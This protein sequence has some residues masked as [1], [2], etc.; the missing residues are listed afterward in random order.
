MLMLCLQ[1]HDHATAQR[2]FANH[3]PFSKEFELKVISSGNNFPDFKINR[4]ERQSLLVALH[5]GI[6]LAHFKSAT[7]LDD[8]EL[9][10]VISFLLSKNW[11]N[12]ESDRYKPNVFIA[13]QKDGNRLYE[14][15]R[16]LSDQIAQSI[17]VQLPKIK[18]DFEKTEISKK[19]SFEEWSFFVLSNVLLDNWQITNIEKGFLGQPVRPL[20]HGK[21]YYA[22]LLEANKDRESFG[23]Y[24]NQ[25]GKVSVYG[26]HRKVADVSSTSYHVSHEDNAIFNG[27]AKGFLPVLLQ[28]LNNNKTFCMNV[29]RESGYAEE[30]AFG[31][32]FMWWYH[33]IY[34]QATDKMAKM[35][36]LQIPETGNFVY[37]IEE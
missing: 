33:F 27:M 14:Y 17:K 19:Q 4:E 8:S 35:E 10:A 20:R 34:T 1:I 29:Y 37:T 9:E 13:T 2:S 32:F 21:H 6:P 5:M 11:L 28:I 18:A 24:G 31:E 26:N 15:A 3:Q 25:Y 30:I 12:Q 22:A 16:P 23:I 7:P 36:M